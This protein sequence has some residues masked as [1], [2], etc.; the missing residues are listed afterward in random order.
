MNPIRNKLFWSLAV[1]L[2]FS[3]VAAA[4]VPRLHGDEA[5]RHG[6]WLGLGLASL[7]AAV[8]AISLAWASGRS[9]TV[10]YRTFFGGI[11]WKVSVL[12]GAFWALAGQ[13]AVHTAS[14][15]VTLA[16]STI[17][18]NGIEVFLLKS[19]GPSAAPS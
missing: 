13:T 3:A 19:A 15:L 1:F 9:D 7:N 17:V 11:F 10:F 6:L 18:F 12:A 4:A 5:V 8:G 14:A 2:I 16:L